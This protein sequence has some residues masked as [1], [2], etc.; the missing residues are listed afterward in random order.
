MNKLCWIAAMMLSL[1]ACNA[2]QTAPSTE[3]DKPAAVSAKV[4]APT[5]VKASPPQ[6]TSNSEAKNMQQGRVT[7]IDLEGGFYGVITPSGD[8]L[9]PTNLDRKYLV[10]GILLQFVAVPQPAMMGIQQWGTRVKL[11]NVSQIGRTGSND[12]RY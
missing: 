9:L 4:A 6:S 12:P 11:E 3:Q 1:S 2:E 8:K 7:Y 10:D 5:V